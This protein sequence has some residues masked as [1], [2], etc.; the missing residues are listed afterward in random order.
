MNRYNNLDIFPFNIDS[1]W[2]TPKNI[3][4]QNSFET[5]FKICLNKELYN[6]QDSYY[7]DDLYKLNK[8]DKTKES[9]K[10]K[11]EENIQNIFKIKEEEKLIGKKIKLGRKKNIE[12]IFNINEN[13]RKIHNNK[14]EDNIINK[15]QIHSINSGIECFNSILDYINYN[16]KERFLKIDIIKKKDFLKLMHHLKRKL[17]KKK[18]KN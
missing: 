12:K 10:E 2:S 1:Y 9:T 15:I 6:N 13:L 8:N 4:F 5:A 16:K 18:E 11:F 3:D 14:D 17:I 7:E